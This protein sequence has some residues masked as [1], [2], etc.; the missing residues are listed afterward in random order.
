[1][2]HLTTMLALALAGTGSAHASGFGHGAPVAVTPAGVTACNLKSG[3]IDGDGRDD[4][5]VLA[6]ATSPQ[7]FQVHIHRQSGSGFDPVQVIDYTTSSDFGNGCGLLLADFD[8][9]GDT[10]I[11]AAQ[12]GSTARVTLLRNDGTGFTVSATQATTAS[13]VVDAA[14][15]DR[16][17][18][19]DV[20]ASQVYGGV[21]LHRGDGAGGLSA[22][23][24]LDVGFGT[25]KVF[26]D[27]TG[28]GYPDMLY[29]ADGALMVHPLASDGFA[30]MP[31]RLM[32]LQQRRGLPESAFALA[33]FDGDARTDIATLTRAS[34]RGT[35]GIAHQGTDGGFSRSRVV[36]NGVALWNVQAADLDGDGRA[37]LL[38]ND[39]GRASMQLATATAAGFA[40]PALTDVLWDTTSVHPPVHGDFNGD[41]VP[42]IAYYDRGFAPGSGRILYAPG[43]ADPSAASD[44]VVG[45]RL[46]PNGLTVTVRNTGA[47]ESTSFSLRAVVDPRYGQLQATGSPPGCASSVSQGTI[48]LG[49]N[50]RTLA[51]ASTWEFTL[52]FTLWNGNRGDM[53]LA[54]ASMTLASPDLRADNN[55]AFA[56][57]KIPPAAAP[58]VAPARSAAPAARRVR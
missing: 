57:L 9:D 7:R 12:G 30:A 45:A 17:G 36:G 56:R 32:S 20:I 10:D 29:A 58:D 51:A 39:N 44:L 42:D 19:L 8:G 53:L 40:P 11:V 26:A 25:R 43:M 41:G 47:M 52:P 2:R 37:D 22:A 48:T 49:C 6:T 34:N 16:D 38:V 27:V 31:T 18:H 5:V 15:I 46:A 24:T 50:P 21:A 4:L 55:R 35:V 13:E 28:D 1:M 54:S 33:D 23:T 14:D 3:D